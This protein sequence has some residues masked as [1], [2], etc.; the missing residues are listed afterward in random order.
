MGNMT[1]C[2]D[3]SD[4]NSM[5]LPTKN[6]VKSPIPNLNRM[7]RSSIAGSTSTIDRSSIPDVQIRE[8]HKLA[9]AGNANVGKTSLL[10]AYNGNDLD[11][12]KPPT[13]I[14]VYKM[15]SLVKRDSMTEFETIDI[16]GDDL[17]FDRR[18]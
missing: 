8:K 16:G 18:S 4:S 11:S 3:Y 6:E 17:G 12:M 10:S 14:D 2:C 15:E 7:D 5:Q 13:D 9:L 1:N